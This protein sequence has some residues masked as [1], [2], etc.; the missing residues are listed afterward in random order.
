MFMRA[1]LSGLPD[2]IWIR[3]SLFIFTSTT[4]T[5]S[6]QTQSSFQNCKLQWQVIVKA[7]NYSQNYRHFPYASGGLLLP[8][9]YGQLFLSCLFTSAHLAA[10]L[11]LPFGE[12][13]RNFRQWSEA[14]SAL[15]SE[16]DSPQPSEVPTAA[17]TWLLLEVWVPTPSFYAPSPTL[18]AVS[19]GYYFCI[20]SL[21]SFWFCSLP[22]LV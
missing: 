15:F 19:C 16:A 13:F 17:G 7:S 20:S 12:G 6:C 8:M 4:V 22:K 18:V 14:E 9:R 10:F 21:L 5:L 1:T 3:F 2:S 11:E